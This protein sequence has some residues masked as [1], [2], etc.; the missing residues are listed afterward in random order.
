MHK[1]LIIHSYTPVLT[2]YAK[3]SNMV[4]LD[5]R[6]KG[7]QTSVRTFYLDCERYIAKDEEAR[8]YNFLDSLGNWTTDIILVNG[9]QATYTLMS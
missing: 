4:A 1:V 5:L 7:I 3:F 8:M 2:A 9:D 6:K